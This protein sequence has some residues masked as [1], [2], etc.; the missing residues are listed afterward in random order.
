M[1]ILV[2]MSYSLPCSDGEPLDQKMDEIFKKKQNG[3]FI[4]LGAYDGLLQSNTAFFEFSRGWKGILVEPSIR[5]FRKCVAA[6]PNSRC[7]HYACVDSKYTGSTIEGDFNMGPMSSVTNRKN[8]ENTGEAPAATLE[9]ILDMVG[10]IPNIDFLSLDTEGYE[11]EVLDGLNLARYRPNYILIEIYTNQYD[12]IV[13]F[14]KNHNYELVKN[15]SNY[16][17][18]ILPGWDGTHNDFLFVDTT[19]QA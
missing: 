10:D 7:F 19:F 14:L 1:D 8:D 4:E 18:E 15:I 6:R 2:T 13:I 12:E 5:E 17:K 9:S 3:F 16:N 11:K